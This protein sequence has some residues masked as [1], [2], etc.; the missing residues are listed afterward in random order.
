MNRDITRD[1]QT[2]VPIHIPTTK[3]QHLFR[4]LLIYACVGEIFYLLFILLSPLP[5]FHLVSTPI[6]ETFPW[7]LFLS[8]SLVAITGNPFTHYSWTSFIL[9]GMTFLGLF[10][11]YAGSLVKAHRTK[12]TGKYSRYYLYFILVVAALFGITLL[13]QPMLL[14]DDIFTYSFSGRI[15]AIYHANP[16][17]TAPHQ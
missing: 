1:L 6:V 8:R 13:F 10:G 15:L 5:G 17:N 11:T 3:Q 2:L 12:S 4:S 7:T 16:L 14:S 9:I